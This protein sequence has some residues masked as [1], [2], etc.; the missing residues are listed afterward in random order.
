MGVD[1]VTPCSSCFVTLNWANTVLKKRLK[2]HRDI[3]PLVDEVLAVSGLKYEGSITVRHILDVF[4]NDIGYKNITLNVENEMKGLK[5]APYY[6]C[7][8][9][10]PNTGFDNTENPETLD[11]LLNALTVQVTEFSSKTSC[12]GSSLILSEEEIAL[13]MVKN[14]LDDAILGGADCIATVCP[15]CQTNLDAFQHRVNKKYKTRYH[16]PVLFF[17]QLMGISM[18]LNPGELG[19][20]SNI[21]AAK[22]ILGKYLQGKQWKS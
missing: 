20:D 3:K 8:I 17:T 9:V 12:C 1:I 6:G 19:L 5:V 15:L 10:R 21:I 4:V 22:N 16:I 14:I 18:G 13:E 2:K 11:K 7:Q